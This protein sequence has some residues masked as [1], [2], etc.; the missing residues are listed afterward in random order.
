VQAGIPKGLLAAIGRVESGQP[1]ATSAGSGWPWTINAKGVGHF[2]Q[3]R[4]QALAVAR[5][6]LASG[7]G[8]MDIGCLQVNWQAHPGAFAS[9]DQAFDP[10][11]NATVA[12]GLLA[13][14]YRQT[15][16]WP[17]ATA[18]YHSMTPGLGQP[19]A[20]KVLAAWA[21][22]TQPDP[23]LPFRAIDGM[24]EAEAGSAAGPAALARTRASAAAPPPMMARRT[25]LTLPAAQGG[26][27]S[28]TRLPGGQTGPR[29]GALTLAA[30]RAFPVRLAFRPP[31][32]RVIANR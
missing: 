11:M 30:Y 13:A 17:R 6:F 26:A 20:R 32:P 18:A 22:A 25:G 7:V 23:R 19:Y 2:Y 29:T 3:N 9:L 31:H 12:A 24:P 1:G 5:H 28:F 10:A 4:A 15:G 21:T 16:T 14:L 8:S 27:R